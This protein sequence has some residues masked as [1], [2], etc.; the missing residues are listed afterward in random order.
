MAMLNRAWKEIST[1]TVSRESSSTYYSSYNLKEE[2]EYAIGV[3][4]TNKLKNDRQKKSLKMLK[5]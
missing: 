5:V 3:I 4:R 2:F 1:Y